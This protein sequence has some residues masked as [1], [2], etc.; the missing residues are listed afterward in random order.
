VIVGL[1]YDLR[2]EY[3]ASGFSEE[4]VAEFDSDQ[5]VD[6]VDS[7]IRQLGHQTERIG[8]A[9]S[10]A[11]KL[12]A[13]HK[14]DLVFNF[15]EGLKGRCRESQVPA[16]LELYG[17]GYTFSDPLVCALTLDKAFAKRLVRDAHLPTPDF[18]VIEN[19]SQ[20]PALS[21]KFPLF[22]KP[23]AEGTGKGI[24]KH[25]K[26]DS[27]EQLQ[28]ICRKLLERFD[29]PVLIEEYLP[30]REFT[31]AVLGNGANACVLGTMEFAIRKDAPAQDYSYQVKELC[32]QFV[33][34]FPMT[35]G[36][37]RCEVEDLAVKTYRILECRDAA[38]VDI[39]LDSAGR[40][41]FLEINPLPGLNP[42]HSDL[43]M[44]AAQEGLSFKELI[45]IIINNALERLKK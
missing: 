29:Q 13:G 43:P 7:A 25:S 41:S 9:F 33:H 40:P 17:I 42:T 20:L 22:A 19:L 24:D 11:K 1:T 3:L 36:K 27:P 30:G 31:T 32:E 37:L 38:R 39:R 28:D 44:I 45:G 18:A 12:A 34:Y 10:L 15:A 21:L 26:I 4:S 16:L 6:A 8:N 23:L 5:T 2:S 35:K 14:W